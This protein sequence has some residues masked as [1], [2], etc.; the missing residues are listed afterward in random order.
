MYFTDETKTM[1]NAYLLVE[2]VCKSIC[3]IQRDATSPVI[4]VNKDYLKQYLGRNPPV[5]W[6]SDDDSVNYSDSDTG[7]IDQP[8]P[9][10]CT[11][12]GRLIKPRD[13]LDL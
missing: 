13:I 12:A 2:D 1:I 5:N 6:V 9:R 8:P 3:R 4:S 7:E 10:K 11:R